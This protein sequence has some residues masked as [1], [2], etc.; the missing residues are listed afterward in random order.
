MKVNY[1]CQNTIKPTDKAFY[2][3]PSVAIYTYN[4]V[5]IKSC[6]ISFA[7]LVFSFCIDIIIKR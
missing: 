3:T 5:S 6:T 2:L 1:I 4:G 7:W